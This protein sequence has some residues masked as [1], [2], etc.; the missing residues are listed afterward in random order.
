[1]PSSAG[2]RH[3]HKGNPMKIH[4]MKRRMLGPAAVAIAATLAISGCSGGG[5]PTDDT[6]DVVDQTQMQPSSVDLESMVTE[7]APAEPTGTLRIGHWVETLSMDPLFA[8]TH[9]GYLLMPSYDTLFEIDGAYQ[10]LPSLVT[11]WTQPDEFTVGLTLRDDVLFHDGSAFTAETVKANFDRAIA[12][13]TAPNANMFS[14]IES[15]EVVDDTHATVHFS[16]AYPNFFYNM[17]TIAGA[18][19]SSEALAAGADLTREEAGSGGWIWQ[20]DLHQEGS[21]H[22]YKA[23]PDYWNGDAVH[24]ETIETT[25]IQDNTARMNAFTSGQIDILSNVTPS[26]TSE[27]P[28]DSLTLADYTIT[29]SLSI[30]DREGALVPALGEEKVREA[31]GYLIDRDGFNAVVFDGQGDAGPGGFASP[32]TVW[33]DEAL[34]ARA[35]D[36][37]KA[38]ALLAEAGYADGFSVDLAITPAI[39]AHA[40]AIQQMLAAG[41]ITVNLIDVQGSEYTAALRKGEYAIGILVPTSIDIDQWWTRSVSNTGPL[42]G[43]GLT[44]LADLEEEYEAAAGKP[45]EERVPV[46]KEIQ[47]QVLERGVAFPLTQQPRQSAISES[48][49]ASEMPIYAPEDWAPRPYYLWIQE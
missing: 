11:A 40:V 28:Q 3:D 12:T 36:V 6:G 48:V 26:Q 13:P 14:L 39:K 5:E 15:T 42:N 8:N 25:V 35:L 44:D 29:V 46:M 32:T 24:V 27:V 41:G 37:E 17:S 18:M 21:K 49:K 23:N 22:V 7:G 9:Q 34:D 4:A 33:Y 47:A 1:M 19:V 10:P 38:T 2:V 45:T 31:V 16:A 43:F 30:F 20:K